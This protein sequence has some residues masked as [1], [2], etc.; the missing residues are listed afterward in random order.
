MPNYGVQSTFQLGLQARNVN[1]SVKNRTSL[2]ISKPVKCQQQ[3]KNK[4]ETINDK[5]REEKRE[6]KSREEKKRKDKKKRSKNR[7]K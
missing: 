7:R 2:L 5:G 4:E 6:Q 1:K 3:R